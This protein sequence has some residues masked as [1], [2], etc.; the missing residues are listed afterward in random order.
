MRIYFGDRFNKKLVTDTR[1]SRI[2]SPALTS[3]TEVGAV[4]PMVE[5]E[6]GGEDMIVRRAG[7]H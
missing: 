1:I 2:R 5:K 4:G 6:E 3:W 7:A